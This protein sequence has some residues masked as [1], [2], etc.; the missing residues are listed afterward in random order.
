MVPEG[1][2]AEVLD[3]WHMDGG[4]VVGPAHWVPL[5]PREYSPYSLP[6]QAESTSGASCGWK[7]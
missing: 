2:A 1:K 7:C 6:L 5:L 3:T 4:Q